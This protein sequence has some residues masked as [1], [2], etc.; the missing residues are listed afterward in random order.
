MNLIPYLTIPGTALRKNLGQVM[1]VIIHFYL[2]FPLY[3]LDVSY[4]CGS[5]K[6]RTLVVLIILFCNIP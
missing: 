4:S 5:M 2:C 6:P 1:N 3:F